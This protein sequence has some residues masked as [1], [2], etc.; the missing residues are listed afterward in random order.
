MRILHV[1]DI[2]GNMGA[3]E[4]IAQKAGEIGADLIAVTGDLTHFGGVEDAETLLERI[5]ESGKQI[6]FVPGNCDP[7]ALLEW[8]PTNSYVKNLLLR[9][10]D[11]SGWEL[12]GLGGAVG[13]YGTLIEFTEEEVEDMLE[14]V[15]PRKGG[16]IFISHSP[17]YGLEVDYTGVKHIGS[18][19]VK[20]YVENYQPKLMMCGHAHEGRGMVKVNETIIVNSGAAKNGYC[21]VID[22]GEGVEVQLMTLY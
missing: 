5:S 14:K 3:G 21:A 11:F 4:K 16:F 18:R 12:M 13:R 6:F 1:S 15:I 9:S 2:H 17:P 10:I 22:L 7:R 19:A 8:T 20:K